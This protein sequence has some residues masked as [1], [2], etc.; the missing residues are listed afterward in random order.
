[1]NDIEYDKLAFDGFIRAIRNE[2]V[3]NLFLFGVG[4]DANDVRMG[5]NHGETYRLRLATNNFSD[6]TSVEDVIKK[7]NYM[8]NS[9]VGRH[10]F[11]VMGRPIRRRRDQ[12]QPQREESTC[13]TNA[14]IQERIM[15]GVN[16]L[17]RNLIEQQTRCNVDLINKIGGYAF[18]YACEQV[19]GEGFEDMMI[20]KGQD[21]MPSVDEVR[22]MI[23]RYAA[24]LGI[25]PGDLDPGRV[26]EI[27]NKIFGDRERN[28]QV[29]INNP[30]RYSPPIGQNRSSFFHHDFDL[31]DDDEFD[32]WARY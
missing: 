25:N 29:T 32:E 6:A 18:K 4:S 2:G 21:G 19:F 24:E 5:L 30:E 27:L 10:E 7:L 14:D 28:V 8:V 23:E 31:Y 15:T 26:N 20:A 11:G 1:M 13:E 22:E 16:I 9:E 3:Y 17:I 12:P